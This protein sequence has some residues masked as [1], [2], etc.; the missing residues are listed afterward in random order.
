ML[1]CMLVCDNTAWEHRDTS[2]ADENPSSC[3]RKSDL[4]DAFYLCDATSCCVSYLD[5]CEVC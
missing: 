1:S 5:M 3:K 4:T 2:A